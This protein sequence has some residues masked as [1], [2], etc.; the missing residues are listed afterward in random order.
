MAAPPLEAT[1]PAL[2]TQL[3]WGNVNADGLLGDG[4]AGIAQV[5]REGEGLYLVSYSR[6]FRSIP[7]V[8]VTPVDAN[9]GVFLT[10]LAEDTFICRTVRDGHHADAPF[11]FLAIGLVAD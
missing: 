6:R 5:S 9:V 2:G 11:S 8:S 7:A 4:A 3:A 1:P 10:S